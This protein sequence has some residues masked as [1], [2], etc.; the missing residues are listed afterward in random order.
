VN[1][2]LLLAT[3]CLGL[4]SSAALAQTYSGPDPQRFLSTGLRTE[5]KG[6]L[7]SG[8]TPMPFKVDPYEAVYLS[9]GGTLASTSE[10]LLF[11]NSAGTTI[12]QTNVNCPVSPTQVYVGA[13]GANGF[14]QIT[15]SPTTTLSATNTVTNYVIKLPAMLHRSFQ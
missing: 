5:L 4:A 8:T 7:N 10:T 2:N 15:A 3:A 12:S 9:C 11:Q 1:K 6:Q 13:A 14:V